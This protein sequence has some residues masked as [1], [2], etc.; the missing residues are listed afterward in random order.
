MAL[1]WDWKLRARHLYD[2]ALRGAVA[3]SN[4]STS[5]SNSRSIFLGTWSSNQHRVD[6]A[7]RDERGGE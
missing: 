1:H 6:P 4:R 2:T 3:A 5:R 7:A